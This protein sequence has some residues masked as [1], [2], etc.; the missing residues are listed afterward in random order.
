MLVAWKRTKG[1]LKRNQSPRQVTD[2][3]TT[4]LCDQLKNYNGQAY[5]VTLVTGFL[6]FKLKKSPCNT[7]F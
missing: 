1:P 3:L 6:G 4:E 5:P 2:A 7:P